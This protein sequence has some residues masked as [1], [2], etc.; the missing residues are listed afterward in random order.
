MNQMCRVPT[1]CVACVKVVVFSTGT[2]EVSVSVLKRPPADEGTPDIMRRH[3]E[4]GDPPEGI[5]H[6]VVVLVV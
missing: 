2:A 4:E 5:I 3:V 1:M 6:R